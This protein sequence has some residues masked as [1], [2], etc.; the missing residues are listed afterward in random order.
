[1]GFDLQFPVKAELK[2]KGSFTIPELTSED[3]SAIQGRADA[4]EDQQIKT[5]LFRLVKEVRRLRDV[6]N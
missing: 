1:M 3:L 6:T 5:D 2:G 4:V